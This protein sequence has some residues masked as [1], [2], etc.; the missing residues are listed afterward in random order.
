VR[1][2]A[3]ACVRALVW[4]AGRVGVCMRERACNAY[5]PY[6]DVIY[7]LSVSTTIFDIIS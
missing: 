4:V 1:V 2:H 7:G 3:Y 6:C 5:A